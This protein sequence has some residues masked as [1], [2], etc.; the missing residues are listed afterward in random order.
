MY[1]MGFTRY[2][3]DRYRVLFDFG[4]NHLSMDAS[5]PDD[6]THGWYAG[7]GLSTFITD[8]IEV[9]GDIKGV[10]SVNERYLEEIATVAINWHFVNT[11]S[12]SVENTSALGPN[13][14]E[15]QALPPVSYREEAVEEVAA[16]IAV[17]PVAPAAAPVEAA[18]PAVSAAPAPAVS[19]APAQAAGSTDFVS[20]AA[21]PVATHTL[22]QFGSNSL[23]TTKSSSQLDQLSQEIKSRDAKAVIE[24][25]TDNVGS[26]EGNKVLSL[27]RAITVKR[28]LK[29]RGVNG[30]KLRAVGMGEENPVATNDTAEGRAQNRR[31]E[32][33]IYD[34][35]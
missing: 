27:D 33:K 8:N 20:P 6:A 15:S 10:Y 35:Q 32:V 29:N 19:P 34:N 4:Y 13:T 2:W 24:G 25:H 1:E 31:V 17:E 18:A 12:A 11:S 14:E 7:T 23:D 16:P 21:V 30:D 22:L 9:R 28:E 26:A 3:G 5:S